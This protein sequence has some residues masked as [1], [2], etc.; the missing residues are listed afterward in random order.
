[1]KTKPEKNMDINKIQ[2]L[3]DTKKVE[4]KRIALY[5]GTTMHLKG[6]IAV[7]DYEG[8]F[9]PLV[10]TKIGDYVNWDQGKIDAWNKDQGLDKAT[11][12][13]MFHQSM[14]PRDEDLD[15]EWDNYGEV[16]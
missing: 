5:D 13:M 16:G 15:T 3:I 14:W 1:M 11:V 10:D 6:T 2:Y 4:G 7:V 12:E 9:H 8:G